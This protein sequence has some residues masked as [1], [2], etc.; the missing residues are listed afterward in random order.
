[1]VRPKS[2]KYG[3]GINDADYSVITRD[4]DGKATL[5][6]VY[7]RWSDMLD[8]CYSKRKYPDRYVCDSWLLFSTFK[9]WY[10][11]QPYAGIFGFDLD[12]DTISIGN[13]CY[14][15]ETCCFIPQWL[16]KSLVLPL[17][18]KGP[19]PFGVYYSKKSKGMTNERSKPYVA[20]VS[21]DNKSV[22]LGY[23]TDAR[24]AHRAWQ[25]GKIEN[26]GYSLRK[27]KELN[28]FDNRVVE[29]IIKVQNKL[30][31]DIENNL[32]TLSYA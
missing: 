7:S 6:S 16:N 5:C 18:T 12:K 21:V 9:C 25:V 10:D 27:Y 23:F 2:L 22:I 17:D 20:K 13:N 26:L 1:M 4:S 14:S 29:G 3:V 19:Y 32:E 28:H 15:P 8:R 31:S 30:K 24:S 11:A